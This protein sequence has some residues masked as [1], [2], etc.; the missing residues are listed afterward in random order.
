MTKNF[1]I[2][3]AC[4]LFFSFS[5][6]DGKWELKKEKNGIKVYT[7]TKSGT[8]FRK[9]KATCTMKADLKDY[10][11]FVRNPINYKKYSN[12]IESVKVIKKTEKSVFYYLKIDM[13]WPV[14]NRDGV[15]ELQTITLTDKKAILKSKAHPTLLPEQTGYVRVKEAT[16]LHSVTVDGDKINIHYE[17]FT[18]PNGAVPAW[19]SNSYLVDG[20]ISNLTEVKKAIGK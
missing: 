6:M 16:T 20:P 9:C 14:Y 4:I 7:A 5:Y 3:S 13:P 1:L 8:S 10:V 11:D 12:K 18:D 19:A 17:A 2:L 15:Y